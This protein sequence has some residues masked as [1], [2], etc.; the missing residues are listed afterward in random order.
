MRCRVLCQLGREGVG[1]RRALALQFGCWEA[2]HFEVEEE[3]QFMVVEEVA[4]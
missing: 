3:V 1:T 2:V 4:G